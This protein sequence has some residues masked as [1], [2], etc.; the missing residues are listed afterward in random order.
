M[1]S[2]QVKLVKISSKHNNLRSGEVVGLTTAMPKVGTNFVMVA[3]AL[4]NGNLRVV[5]TGPVQ[6]CEHDEFANLFRF[7]TLNSVYELHVMK[8]EDHEQTIN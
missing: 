8:E 1:D 3:P 7:T 2:I 4:E 6:K 5:A